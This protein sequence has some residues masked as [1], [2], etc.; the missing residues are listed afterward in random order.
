MKTL[1]LAALVA[2]IVT[3]AATIVMRGFGINVDP[4]DALISGLAM[5]VMMPIVIARTRRHKG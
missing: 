1:W 5:G 2:S 3:I 4:R